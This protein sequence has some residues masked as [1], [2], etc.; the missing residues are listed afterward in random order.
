MIAKGE[1]L[2]LWKMIGRGVYSNQRILCLR[3]DLEVPFKTPPAKIA[4]SIRPLLDEDVSELL[5]CG[6]EVDELL[7][8]KDFLKEKVPTCYVAVTEDGHPCYMQWLMLAEQNENIQAYFGDAF[9]RLKQNEGLLEFAYCVEKYRGMGIM[10]HSMAEIAIKGKE[11]GA[12]WIITFVREDNIPSLKGCKRAGF[13]PYLVHENK[14]RF[15]HCRSDIRMLPPNTPYQF[16]VA[17]VH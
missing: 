8:R 5:E 1:G 13:S 10:Q 15:F 7:K 16:E 3:R 9:P 11:S 6:S 12:R 2:S 4:L 17:S 14:W